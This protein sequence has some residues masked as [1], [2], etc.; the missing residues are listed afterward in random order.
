[1]GLHCCQKWHEKEIDVHAVQSNACAAV[2]GPHRLARALIVEVGGDDK[3]HGEELAKLAINAG[4]LVL[5]NGAVSM[6]G[7]EFCRERLLRL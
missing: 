3:L 1:L 2:T 7:V 4:Y 5:E 6:D